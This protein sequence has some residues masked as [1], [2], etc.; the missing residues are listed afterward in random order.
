ML[1]HANILQPLIDLFEWLLLR[2][3]DDLGLGWGMS[4]IGM[5]LL[6]RLALLPLTLKQMRA[7]QNLARHQPE[8][9]KLQEKYKGDRER[10]NQEMMKFYK[11]NQVN[12]FAS[13]LPLLAQFPVFI[14]LFYMLRTDLRHD[15]CPDINP[16]GTVNPKPCGEGG[17]AEFFFIPDLTSKAVGAVLVVLLILYVASQMASTLLSTVSADKT[18]RMIFLLLPVFFVPLVFTFP[19]GLLLYWI[20][21]N[22]WTIVQGVI[23]RRRVGPM[24]PPEE[25]GGGDAPEERSGIARMLALPVKADPVAEGPPAS[26]G[27]TTAAPPPPPRKKK[28]RSG[29]RR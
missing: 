18:Q 29:R 7:M 24:K 12:P 23:V 22:L 9:K 6:I 2:F 3:H 13:C 25:G 15:I 17:D 20:T 8:L 14:A 27:R 5:T 11:E 26:Q 28:K 1:V 19:A 10:L 16:I 21:T 4:I